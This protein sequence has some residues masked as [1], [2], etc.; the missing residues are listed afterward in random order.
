MILPVRRCKGGIYVLLQNDVVK[1]R[2][3]TWAANFEADCW[4]SLSCSGGSGSAHNP[5][6]AETTGRT[7]PDFASCFG[8]YL[9][10]HSTTCKHI[11]ITIMEHHGS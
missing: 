11:Q 10:S 6:S 7:V 4:S 1:V 9:A 5:Q 3:C 8:L 2:K